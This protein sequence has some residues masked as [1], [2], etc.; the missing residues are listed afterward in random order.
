MTA[1]FP[2]EVTLENAGRALELARDACRGG[3]ADLSGLARFDSAAVAVLVALRREFGANL[4]F[5]DPPANL[6]KLAAVYGVDR[7]LFET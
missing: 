4:R 5:I 2:A 1:T 3:K 7:V 6:R